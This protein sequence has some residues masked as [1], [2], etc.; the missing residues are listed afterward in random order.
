MK[1]KNMIEPYE[2]KE[3]YIFISYCHKNSE[4]V[5]PVLEEL[6]ARGYCFWYDKGVEHGEAWTK[7]VAEHEDKARAVIAFMS[8]DFSES[9]NCIDELT[10]AKQKRI[11]FVVVYMDAEQSP[12]YISPE[13]E[14]MVLRMHQEYAGDTFNNGRQKEIVNI[15]SR[16]KF[17]AEC[18]NKDAD[19]NNESSVEYVDDV[20]ED[21][22]DIEQSSLLADNIPV[23]KTAK[24][25]KK[26]VEI[27]D[28]LF[29][30]NYWQNDA[31]IKEP[32]EWQVLDKKDGKGLMISKYGLDCQ[33]YH[34]EYEA[35]TWENC[36]LRK[37]LNSTFINDAFTPAEQLKILDA[38]VTEN[39]I[40]I[41]AQCP[42]NDSTDKIFLLS[43]NEVNK[44]FTT[45]ESRECEPTLYAIA[46]GSY[47]VNS[48][49]S[50]DKVT[51]WWWLRSRGSSWHDASNVCDDGSVNDYGLSGNDFHFCVRPALW[52][53][54]DS[55]D[56]IAPDSKEN[57]TT[58]EDNP[59]DEKPLTQ[60][61]YE[62]DG[63][64]VN[65]D[66]F[67]TF[68][69][70]MQSDASGAH[71]TPIEWQVLEIKDDKA[72]LISRYVL[73][74]KPYNDSLKN[75]TWDDCS[76]RRWLNE[77]F[78]N[79]VFSKKEREA[80]IETD[81]NNEKNPYYRVF[82]GENTKDKIF[83][84]SI[85]EVNNY[86]KDN[87]LRK[88][89]PTAYAKKQGVYTNSLHYTE[90]GYSCWWWL[91]S[92]GAEHDLA[93]SVYYGGAVDIFGRGV[94]FDKCGVRPALW[95]DLKKMK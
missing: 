60:Q 9:E 82:A 13:I 3:P 5:Y 37:W 57:P 59:N 4:L 79:K 55:F 92:P 40:Y 34:S 23:V 8:K 45:C 7:V 36:T 95:V 6:N 90:D 32:I 47:S 42:D 62:V 16:D 63:S 71:G 30:G 77:K 75:T 89:A 28:T 19:A 64:S 26:N 81:V 20:K 87:E 27:G 39:K 88:C 25:T 72:L 94:D 38:L 24:N 69:K 80:I 93:A 48:N 54:L 33:R 51:C 52:I 31:D 49:M 1:S 65:V 46:R 74:S 84:L 61:T 78:L 53:N 21:R 91:R 76:L 58:V 14:M 67:V 68:G 17:M 15:L 29:F 10:Y 73:D 41:I 50:G 2:G 35:S 86:F 85:S 43:I 11:Q 66:G 12:N 83:L 56:T 44:F 70:Y 22:Y 18:K